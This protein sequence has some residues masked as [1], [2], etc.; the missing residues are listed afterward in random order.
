MADIGGLQLL[1]ETRKKIEIRIPG[2]NKFLIFSFVFSLIVL[3]AYFSLFSYE[4][5]LNSKSSFLDSQLS[6]IEKSRDKTAETNLLNLSSQLKIINP[7]LNNHLIWS[8]AFAEIQNLTLPQIQ[9]EVLNA[10]FD[11]KKYVFKATAANYTTVAKQIAAF[12]GSDTFTDVALD[13]VSSQPSGRVEFMLELIFDPN[14][15]LIK[16]IPQTK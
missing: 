15:F 4:S 8:D 14:K 12:Y 16:P 5:S 9:Y 1:P 3:V 6:A 2:Q 7:L 11:S 10:N 13:K